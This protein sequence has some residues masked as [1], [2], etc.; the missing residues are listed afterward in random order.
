MIERGWSRGDDVGLALMD[1]RTEEMVAVAA[2]GPVRLPTVPQPRIELH[3]RR[4]YPPPVPA[5]PDA[6]TTLLPVA[7]P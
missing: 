2:T 3:R 1:A 7:S 4:T 6:V 5:R